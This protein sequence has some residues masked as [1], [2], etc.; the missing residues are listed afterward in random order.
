VPLCGSSKIAQTTF[1]KVFNMISKEVDP[2]PDIFSEH[3]AS[4]ISTTLSHTVIKD[5]GVTDPYF[6]TSEWEKV[7]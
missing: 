1:L 6:T 4:L 7:L 3:L 2:G 5:E